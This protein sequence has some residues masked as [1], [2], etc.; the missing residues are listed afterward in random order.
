MIG[1]HLILTF[2]NTLQNLRGESITWGTFHFELL[3]FLREYCS[4]RHS[5]FLFTNPDFLLITFFQIIE[6]ILNSTDKL[7]IQDI[8]VTSLTKYKKQKN[9]FFWQRTSHWHSRF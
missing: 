8:I 6:M 4:L 2:L 3:T 1:I 9:I 7:D 5:S